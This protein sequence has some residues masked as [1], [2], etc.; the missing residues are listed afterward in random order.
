MHHRSHCRVR[1]AAADGRSIY[2]RIIISGVTISSV[3]L[4]GCSFFDLGH[5]SLRSPDASLKIPAI[6]QAADHH[7]VAAIPTLIRDLN[8]TDPAVRFYSSYALKRITGRELGYEYYAPEI[9]RRLA[10]ARWDQWAA[11]HLHKPR[12]SAGGRP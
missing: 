5:P 3:L 4:G 9:Q 7:D 6:K 12:S 8:S 10:I 11:T 2:L 1:S